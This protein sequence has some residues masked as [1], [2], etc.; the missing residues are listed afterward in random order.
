[1]T[2]SG[3]PLRICLLCEEIFAW[4]K[5][6]GFG[7]AMRTIGRCLVQRRQSVTAIVPRRAGQGPVEDLD[8]IRVLGYE[9]NRPWQIGRLARM[10]YA[11]VYHSCEP[12]FASYA[13][14]RAMPDRRHIVTVRDLRHELSM[15]GEKNSVCLR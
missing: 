9:Q 10:A 3:E 11:D 12:S 8:G 4:D 15:T 13:A 5:Y 2:C 7:R 1:M 14:Q 6:G